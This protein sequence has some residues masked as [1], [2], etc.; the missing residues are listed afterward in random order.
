MEKISKLFD[1]KIGLLLFGT[2]ELA[3]AYAFASLALDSG[4]LWAYFFTIVFLILG[5]KKIIQLAI[6]K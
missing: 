6:S 1:H 5:I 4:S 2:L 3:L